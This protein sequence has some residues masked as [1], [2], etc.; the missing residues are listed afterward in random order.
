[1]RLRLI[2]A[3]CAATCLAPIELTSADQATASGSVQI[4]GD[5]IGGVVTGPKGPEAGVWV[6]AETTDLPT[7]YSKIVVTDDQGRYVIPDLPAANYE[8]WV[9]GYG[10]VDSPKVKSGVGKIV[11]LKAVAAPDAHAAAQYYPG[12]YWYAMLKIPPESDFPGTGPQGNGISLTVKSQSQWINVLK[13]SGCQPCHQLGDKATRELEP[14]LGQFPNSVA[15]WDRRLKSGQAGTYMSM[16]VGAIGKDRA[17]TMFADWTD[18]IAKG[19]V[20]FDVPPKPTGI[21]RN[22]VITNW[23][24][25]DPD[26]YIHDSISTDKRHPTVNANG[27]IYGSTEV[28]S[29]KIDVLD[30][31]RNV[32]STITVPVRDPDTPYASSQ[33]MPEPSPYFGGTPIWKGKANVHNIMLDEKGRLWL[34]STIR[35]SENPDYCREGSALPSAKLLPLRTGDRQLSMYDPVSGKF[36]LIDLCFGT[37][38]L[39]FAENGRLWFSSPGTSVAGWFDTKLFEKTQDAKTAQGWTALILDTDGNGKREED[40]VAPTAPV[41]PAKDKRIPAT[42]YSVIENPVDH[43]IWGSYV[44]FPGGIVRLDLGSN[45][46]ATTIA[47][48]YEP[49]FGN[50]KAPVQGYTPRGI[51]VDRDGVIWTNLSGSSHLASFDRRKC[52]GPLNGPKATG[53]QCPEGWT[54]YP[55]PGPQF[56]GVTESGSAGST[57]Y[58]WVDQF[59]T[60]GLGENVP[61]AMGNGSDA[62]Y[63]LLPGT[64]KFVTLR[65]PYP[66]S[67]FVKAI[68][69]RIDDPS[70]GWKGRGL[71]TSSG[72][73]APWHMEGGLGERPKVTKFQFRP[74]PLAH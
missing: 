43:S 61:I 47:E 27:P 60:F 51:D 12:N 42:F 6:I 28:A 15:A 8:I 29:D 40:Y 46:P 39:Q 5:D 38:H 14:Q 10:L 65:V 25:G 71:W 31:V 44:G 64:G 4:D 11:D 19:E 16:I 45:P 57:Y 62:L 53:Q 36:T 73:R 52:K 41:D 70:A 66:M 33:N 7:K 37:H 63:A 21:E 9:R 54:L 13:T 24:F 49:P 72:T 26:S 17:L 23:D 74:D 67:F 48:Y 50:P 35:P 68:D 32:A 59:N 3:L 55:L 22:I 20:P 2:A 58:V 30:P 18:R 34:T 69:G 1:M 56:H